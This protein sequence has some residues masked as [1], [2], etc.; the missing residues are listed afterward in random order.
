MGRVN[1]E[2]LCLSVRLPALQPSS[3][4]SI[5]AL[6]ARGSID[7]NDNILWERQLSSIID[8][9]VGLPYAKHARSAEEASVPFEDEEEEKEY[10]DSV[11]AILCREAKDTILF[12]ASNPTTAI[13]LVSAV[14]AALRWPGQQQQEAQAKS[15]TTT[16]ESK[17]QQQHEEEDGEDD[18]EDEDY[19]AVAHSG[20][21]DAELTDAHGMTTEGEDEDGGVM[22]VAKGGAGEGGRAV[23]GKLRFEKPRKIKPAATTGSEPIAAAT[24]TT[25]AAAGPAAASSSTDAHQIAAE[26]S[27]VWHFK[28]QARSP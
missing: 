2:L 3:S 28:I 9:A 26:A 14:C 25:T 15:T 27:S 23:G 5:P 8:L 1:D 10:N 16:T 7:P 19:I 12:R 13:A 17:A 22:G 6:V 20:L 11:V 21:T 24:A 18:D 4:S